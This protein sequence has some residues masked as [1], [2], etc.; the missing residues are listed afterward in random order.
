MATIPNSTSS[1]I[2]KKTVKDFKFIKEIGNGSYS[3][4]FLAI[5]TA[6]NRELAI[7]A[8]SK[9]LVTRLK[10][11]SQV[12]REKDILARLTD[13]NYAAKL[14]CTFQDDKTL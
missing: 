1:R 6:T 13:C 3:T 9:D 10:K 12:F 7:K 8:V 5:E 4:V 11:I 2:P 14:Y